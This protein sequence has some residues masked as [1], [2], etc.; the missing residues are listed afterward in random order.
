MFLTLHSGIVNPELA[1]GLATKNM[2]LTAADVFD[3]DPEV[4]LRMGSFKL[5][6]SR[7]T[8]SVEAGA[9]RFARCYSQARDC[10]R[11]TT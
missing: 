7:V 1:T 2:R 11:I 5:V 10:S 3:R 9:F 6:R 4:F 8:E